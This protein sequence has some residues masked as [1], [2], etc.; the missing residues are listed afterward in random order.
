MVQEAAVARARQSRP[1]IVGLALLATLVACA[2]AM[3]SAQGPP[4]SAAR[5]TLVASLGQRLVVEGRR[6]RVQDL[7]GEWHEGQH[8]ARLGRWSMSYPHATLAGAIAA[9]GRP[10]RC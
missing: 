10:S 7:D 3:A 4:T 9:F 8:V 6:E 2:A 1:L 5:T